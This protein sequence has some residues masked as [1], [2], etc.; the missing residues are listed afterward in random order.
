M[1][2]E[3]VWLLSYER[4]AARRCFALAATGRYEAFAR[5]VNSWGSKSMTYSAAALPGLT[6][7]F[8]V[9][10]LGTL[11]LQDFGVNPVTYAIVVIGGLGFALGLLRAAQSLSVGIR[12]RRS[13]RSSAA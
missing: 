2:P 1:D 10:L 5:N 12:F 8:L 13:D 11:A 9:F 7:W 4:L 3:D 6:V